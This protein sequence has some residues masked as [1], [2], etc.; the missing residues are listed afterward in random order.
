MLCSVSRLFTS[1]GDRTVIRSLHLHTQRLG[2]FIEVHH[3]QQRWQATD[4]EGFITAVALQCV[5]PRVVIVMMSG[6]R[7]SF[8]T[9]TCTLNAYLY[10]CRPEQGN[11]LRVAGLGSWGC[12]VGLQHPRSRGSPPLHDPTKLNFLGLWVTMTLNISL[13]SFQR[14]LNL[15][16]A[17]CYNT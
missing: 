15:F 8:F 12:R 16:W 2:L 1:T 14:F 13:T 11:C 10:W 6:L 3:L 7:S 17:A 4:Q 5:L 9:S